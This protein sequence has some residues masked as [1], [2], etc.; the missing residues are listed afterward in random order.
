MNISLTSE[1]QV[2]SL[3]IDYHKN[4]ILNEE[5]QEFC[6]SPIEAIDNH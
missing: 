3:M 2:I 1:A 5:V 6:S 4:I